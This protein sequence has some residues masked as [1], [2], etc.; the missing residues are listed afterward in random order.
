MRTLVYN[1]WTIA[2]Q[3]LVSISSF[4]LSLFVPSKTPIENLIQSMHFSKT[5]HEWKQY[6]ETADDLEGL[7]LW[8]SVDDCRDYDYKLIKARL[9]SLCNSHSNDDDSDVIQTMFL[10]RAGMIRNLGGI[11]NTRLFR[12]SR[13]GTKKLIEDYVK[14]CEEQL[15]K[16][17]KSKHPEL[18]MT[19]KLDFF[20]DMTRTFGRTVLIL[21][22]GA[23]FGLCHL[24]VAKSLY[25]EE[26]L[27][28]I[29]CG[30]YIGALMAAAICVQDDAGLRRLF[31]GQSLN[32]TPFRKP[33]G[34]LGSIFRKMYRFIAHGCF[35]D[36]RVVEQCAQRNIGDITFK[37]AYFKSGRILNIVVNRF[38]KGPILLNYITA[39]DVIVWSAACASCAVPGIYDPVT[40]YS[41]C[42]D[43]G[44]V[45]PWHPSTIKIESA[46]ISNE[47]PTTR[48]TELF[49]ANNFIVSQVPSYFSIQISPSDEADRASIFGK[50]IRLI[51]DEVAHRYSQAK[52]IGLVP[53]KLQ[54]FERFF[55]APLPG[56]VTL[57]PTIRFSD[58]IYIIRNPC[59]AFLQYCMEKGERSVWKRMSQLRIRSSIEYEMEKLMAEMK[60][61]QTKLGKAF[62]RTKASLDSMGF[63]EGKPNLKLRARSFEI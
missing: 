47:I 34:V 36:V 56:D 28:K 3:F 1:V 46:M 61:T 8:R 29:I 4:V 38:G 9:D 58:I 42:P 5:Y 39:P 17:A 12:F 18:R 13:V 32:L 60:Q 37:E 51:G 63:G 59:P 26:L 11:C 21:H 62:T 48:L 45:R 14:E 44:K 25:S 19:I 43:T 7:S 20:A 16:I 53:S 41:K 33:G 10:L 31:T 49:N 30:V 57:S 55:H 54:Y 40:L 6:A 35:L 24:G 27:P 15:K 2:T 50:I 23:A 52:G 22:G